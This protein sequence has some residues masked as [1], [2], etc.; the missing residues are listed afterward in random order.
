MSRLQAVVGIP[1]S[2]DQLI[3]Y[4]ST[5]LQGRLLWGV[6]L[7]SRCM[8]QQERLQPRALVGKASHLILVRVDLL[9]VA[10]G[11]HVMPS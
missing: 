8:L 7:V 10:L 3:T 4:P 2:I 9:P 6:Y 1:Q 5:I 11:L